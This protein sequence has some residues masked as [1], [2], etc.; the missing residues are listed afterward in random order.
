VTL[1]LVLGILYPIVSRV[2]TGAGVEY[3]RTMALDPVVLLAVQVF[4]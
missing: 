4:E 2:T 1:I 3:L